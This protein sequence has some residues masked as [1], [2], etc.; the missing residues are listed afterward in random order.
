MK[1]I[2]RDTDYAIRAI[3]Y[4]AKH[5]GTRVSAKELVKN[6]RVPRSFLR[7][8]LQ[9][10]EK[11]GLLRSYKGKGG[12]FILNTLPREIFLLDLIEVFQG[13]FS[14]NECFLKKRACPHTKDCR[15]RKKIDKIHAYVL[16]ELKKI[17]IAHL[18]D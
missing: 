18:L 11:K 14:L 10:M 16:A 7:K 15:L 13:P 8:I 12:G 6:L 1:L 5:K 2:T 17:N 4:M 3:T 9:V